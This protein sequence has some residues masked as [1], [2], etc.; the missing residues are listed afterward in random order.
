M[1]V[2]LALACLIQQT[3]NS[4]YSF[5]R[6]HLNPE[7]FM[8]IPEILQY[9]GYPSEEYQVLTD[10]GYYLQLNRIPHGKHCPHKEEPRPIVLLVHGLLWEG[11]CWIANLPSNSLGFFLADV[12]YDVW[13]IN[14]RGTTWSRRHMEFSIYQQKFWNFSFH[15]MAIY[16]IPA[17]INFILQKTKQDSL[18][19]IGHSQGAGIGFVAFATL[20]YLTDRVKLFISLTPTYTLKGFVAFATL[21]YLTDRVKL[22]ISL[23]PTYTL[24]GISGTFGVLGRIPERFR[25]LIWG[26]KEFSLYSEKVKNSMI[27]ACSYP[28]ID[29]LCLNNIFLAGG[30]NKK[31]LNVSR[32]DVFA[33][34]FPDFTSVKNINHWSQVIHS[35]EFK[36][37]DY[38]LKNREV[39]NMTTP[40]FYKIEDVLVPVAVWSGGKDIVTKRRNIESLITR[41]TYL[42]FYTDIPDW[43]HFDPIL[44]L[45]AVQRCYPDILELMQ[46]HKH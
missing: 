22:F 27:H 5:N 13:I 19:F 23:T 9:W 45:D 21:P 24:K 16:D 3:T 18:Y 1:W 7:G 38:G 20:P 37:Y 8:T 15:E 11:R 41:I 36:Y 40:P 2:F 32:A 4:E 44:G 25:E 28:G 43:Q 12:G 46:K 34:I 14:V 29:R 10:D 17:T 33:G 35:G 6:R 30:Y 42:V 31:N 39:Y 26:T